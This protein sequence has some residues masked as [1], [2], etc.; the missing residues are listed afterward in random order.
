MNTRAFVRNPGVIYVKG[1]WGVEEIFLAKFLSIFVKN[2]E[3]WSKKV[4]KI[5]KNIKNPKS[6]KMASPLPTSCVP[7]VGNPWSSTFQLNPLKTTATQT[8]FILCKIWRENHHNSLFY[9]LAVH[10][11]GT[12]STL[13]CPGTV[14]K[15]EDSVLRSLG[16]KS[17]KPCISRLFFKHPSFGSKAWSKKR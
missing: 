6:R 16:F 5:I 1:K 3:S 15:A 13:L 11:E 17:F 10:L 14:V 9:N 7:Q 12:R 2:L 8:L 4:L